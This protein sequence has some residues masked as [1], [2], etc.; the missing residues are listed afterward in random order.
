MQWPPNASKPSYCVI[1]PTHGSPLVYGGYTPP[2]GHVSENVSL[3][4][5]AVHELSVYCVKT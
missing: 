4:S 1:F 3:G 2:P 5:G